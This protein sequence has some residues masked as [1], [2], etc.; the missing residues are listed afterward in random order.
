[1]QN[2]GTSWDGMH[3]VLKDNGLE[4]R[5]RANGLVIADQDGLM[6]KASSVSRRSF[7]KTGLRRSLVNLLRL[8]TD[9]LMLNARRQKK[10]AGRPVRQVS[11]QPCYLTSTKLN[12]KAWM[13]IALRMEDCPR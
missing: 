6:V 2:G 12:S 1:M 3:Q 4:L 10:Y 8:P 7:Q 11:I 9:L 13:P 5:E